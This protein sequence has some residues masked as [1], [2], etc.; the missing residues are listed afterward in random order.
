MHF[1]YCKLDVSMPCFSKFDISV[2]AQKLLALKKINVSDCMN[3]LLRMSFLRRLSK[4]INLTKCSKFTLFFRAKIFMYVDT[5]FAF[6]RKYV[7][8]FRK[9][10]KFLTYTYIKD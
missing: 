8:N 9:K 5:K 10:C 7:Q 4:L 1:K 3:S 2:T 6:F